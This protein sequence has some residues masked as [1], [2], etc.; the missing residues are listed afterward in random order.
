MLR[1]FPHADDIYTAAWKQRIHDYF[2]HGAQ[3]AAATGYWAFDFERQWAK[4]RKAVARELR[5]VERL[6]HWMPPVG[7]RVLVMGSWLGAE[8]IAYAL[9]GAEVTAIDLDGEALRLSTELAARYGTSIETATMDATAT[10]LPAGHFDLVSCSQVLEHLPPDRQPALLAE[11]WRLCRPGGLL[12]LD[13]PNQLAICDQHDTGLYFVHW[14]PRPLKTRLAR[15]IG[16]DVPTSEPGF[17]F[18]PVGL[19]YYIS[20]FGLMRILRRLG[21]LEVLSRYR[22]FADVEHYA[23]GRYREGRAGP[24]FPLKL[25]AMRA[26]MRVWN[27]NWIHDI[28]LVV[29]KR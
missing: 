4:H 16:R 1:T 26:V 2:S 27:F 25:A 11:M 20:Y 23:A 7:R 10:K 14:L 5:L 28:R 22:G 29:R 18:Q 24:L 6:S 17:G 9:C 15:W 19:H 3:F 21:S 8:A 13:T 12:W